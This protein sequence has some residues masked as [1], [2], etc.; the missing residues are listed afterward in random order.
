MTETTSISPAPDNRR[1]AILQQLA[2]IE[3]EPWNGAGVRILYAC[4]SGSR[5][6]GFASRDSDWDVRFLYVHPPTWYLSVADRRDV[7][8]LPIAD[9]LD[10]NGWEL[11]KALRLLRKG[12]PVLREWLHSPIVYRAAPGVAER[13]RRLAGTQASPRAALHHYLHMA[14][15]NHREYLQG[16]AVRLKKYLY[17]LRPLLSCLWIERGLGQPPVELAQLVDILLPMGAVRTAILDRVRRKCAGE[18]L[19]RGPAIPALDAFLGREL[20]RLGEGIAIPPQAANEVAGLDASLWDAVMGSAT[21]APSEPERS[22]AKTD[23]GRSS[24]GNSG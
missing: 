12:N 22:G 7:I 17:V 4:E 8:E 5:A 19:E 15:R 24:R 14:Q 2:A 20:V 21:E 23:A 18:E 16:P 10:I 13:L 1:A 6:W 11:R 3:A 9:D